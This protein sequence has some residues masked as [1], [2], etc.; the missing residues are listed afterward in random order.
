M[1]VERLPTTDDEWQEAV[2]CA[3]FLLNLD[4]VRQ[5]AMERAGYWL[6]GRL[7]D[8]GPEVNTDRCSELLALGAA[9]GFW[10]REEE[11]E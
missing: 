3:A 9:R 1:T 2:D 10:P 4:A 8:G 5:Y 6:D 7:I 11:S